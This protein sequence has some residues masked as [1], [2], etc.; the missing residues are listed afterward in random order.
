ML[1][2]DALFKIQ[3]DVIREVAAREPAIFVCR[4][5]DYILRD[6]RR[7]LSIFI[8]AD[9]PDRVSRICGRT[10]FTVAEVRQPL[11]LIVIPEPS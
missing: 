11:V 7:S 2:G 3:S 5:A 4:C 1:S 8:T 6:P 10:G 9:D